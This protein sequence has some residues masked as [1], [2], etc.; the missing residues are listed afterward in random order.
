MLRGNE[1]PRPTTT[2]SID[3]PKMTVK[4]TPVCSF[5]IGVVCT[6]DPATR[7]IRRIF[8]SEVIPGS[9]ASED[10]LKQV[11]EILAI[12]G[13]TVAGV[14]GDI[15]PGAWPFDQ[16][17]DREAGETIDVEVAVRVIKKLTLLAFRPAEAMPPK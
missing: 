7:K 17:A 16:L 3:R 15:K 13:R 2:E 5:G 4:G 10:G 6:R 1:K 12:N 9:L 14:E 8:I 11:D